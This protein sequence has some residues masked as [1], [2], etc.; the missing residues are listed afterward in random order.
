MQGTVVIRSGLI[1]VDDILLTREKRLTTRATLE[2]VAKGRH[3]SIV[4][5]AC[6]EE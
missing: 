3:T 5:L 4:A 2:P 6:V 1:E